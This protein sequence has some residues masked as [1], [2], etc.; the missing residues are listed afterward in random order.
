MA[1]QKLLGG[2]ERVEGASLLVKIES[3]FL[4]SFIRDHRTK[5]VQEKHSLEFGRLDVIFPVMEYRFHRQQD[6]W[7]FC[8]NCSKWP[9]SEFDVVSFPIQSSYFDLCK[10]CVELNSHGECEAL[11]PGSP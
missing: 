7:H 2:P 10:E 6:I 4:A 8:R 3:A 9:Q 11:P 5:T 1:V